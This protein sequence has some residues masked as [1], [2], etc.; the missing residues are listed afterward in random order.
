MATQLQVRKS[1]SFLAAAIFAL[2]ASAALG[3]GLG[4]ALKSPVAVTG[5]VRAAAAHGASTDSNDGRNECVWANHHK[6]C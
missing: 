5:Q 3:G 1:P 2:T 6:S 4:Y